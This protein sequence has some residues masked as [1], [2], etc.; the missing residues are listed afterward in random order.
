MKEALTIGVAG[1]GTMGRGMRAAR[2][3]PNAWL[4]RRA[5]L[6]MPLGTPD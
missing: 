3:R 1:A 4:R 2:H 5:E 6:G